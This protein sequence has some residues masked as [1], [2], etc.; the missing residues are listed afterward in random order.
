MHI[1]VKNRANFGV[2][3]GALEN[4]DLEGLE[5]PACQPIQSIS[6]SRMLFLGGR[7]TAL[8][9]NT[10]RLGSLSRLS[11]SL[12][13]RWTEM[14][15]SVWPLLSLNFISKRQHCP[16]YLTLIRSESLC[17]HCP[18]PNSLTLS[19]LS[20]SASLDSRPPPSAFHS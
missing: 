9:H 11:P 10:P 19:S 14:T 1:W 12:P 8:K 16:G 3:Q 2:G 20:L 5:M 4:G 6:F 18:P 13:R 17:F 7:H 15:S